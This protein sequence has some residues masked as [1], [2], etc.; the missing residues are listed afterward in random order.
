MAN[1]N[2][3]FLSLCLLILVL[4]ATTAKAAAAAPAPHRRLQQTLPRFDDGDPR[5]PPIVP[6]TAASCWKSILASE[7]CVDDVLQSLA[8]RQVRISKACCSVLERIGDR[9]VAA[10]FSSFPFNPTYRHIVKNVCGLTA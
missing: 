9:C 4:S 1:A 3:C 5:G 2:H 10:A 8:A 7:S 6:P